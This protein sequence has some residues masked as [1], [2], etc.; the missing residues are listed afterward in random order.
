[1]TFDENNIVSSDIL[2]RNPTN[3]NIISLELSEC[4]THRLRGDTLYS[5]ERKNDTVKVNFGYIDYGCIDLY[6]SDYSIENDTLKIESGYS[7]Y[8]ETDANGNTR[9]VETTCLCIYD[10]ELTIAQIESDFTTIKVDRSVI[11]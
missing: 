8:V 6:F 1:M 3:A 4:N 10:V 5:V 2:R 7:E 9:T 11:N